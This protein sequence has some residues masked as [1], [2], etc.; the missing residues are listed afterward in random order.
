MNG[1]DMTCY[2]HL[3]LEEGACEISPPS[4]DLEPSEQETFTI[5]CN[6]G[7]CPYES[8]SFWT[9]GAGGVILDSDE[10]SAT[11]E[12]TGDATPVTLQ[13]SPDGYGTCTA[14][15]TVEN[16]P[17]DDLMG[18]RIVPPQEYGFPGSHHEFDIW[19]V[20]GDGSEVEGC[21]GGSDFDWMFTEGTEWVEGGTFSAGG[22]NHFWADVDIITTLWGADERVGIFA[23]VTGEENEEVDCDAEILLPS[24]DCLD[25]I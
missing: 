11:A 19:C 23:V 17:E 1:G 20:Y 18:C 13:A 15:I 21:A 10:E 8:D 2:C 5:T 3:Y 22:D 14:I 16:R 25:L 6:G 9:I 24:M 4:A 12:F 7:P